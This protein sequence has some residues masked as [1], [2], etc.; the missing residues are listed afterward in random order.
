MTYDLLGLPPTPEE[1]EAFVAQHAQDPAAAVEALV[2]RLLASPRYGERWGRHWLD[3]VRFGESNGFERN[4][5]IDDLWPFRDYVIRSL[6]EDKPFNQFIIEQL[7]GDVIGHDQPDVEVAAAFLVAGPYDDVGNQDVV[8]QAN[9]RA[10]TLDDIIT[11]TSGAFL[12]LTV[13]CARCH[14]HKFDPVPTED[15]YRMRAAF[16]GVKHG[17][18]VVASPEERQ[19]FAAATKPLNERQAQ[20][21]SEQTELNKAIDARSRSELKKRTF[22]R[23]KFDPQWTEEPFEPVEAR[24]VKFQ[25]HANTGNPN[26]AVGSRLV[27]FEVWTAGENSR[28]VALASNGGRAEG[29]RSATAE[30]F[31]E[32]YGPQFTIDGKFSEQWFIGSPAELTITLAQPETIERI[33]FGNSRGV[34]FLNKKVQGETPCDYQ[35]LVSLDGKEWQE[36][37]TSDDREPWSDRHALERMRREV[38]T[39]EESRRLGELSRELAQVQTRAR[40]QSRRCACYGSER[41][42]SRRSRRWCIS[43]AT[44]RS[45]GNRCCQA[46]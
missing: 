10:A 3:V 21:A 34:T 36:V 41:L 40:S 20:L 45:R 27:E 16:E 9:I 31:P 8:A 15:Y 33:E 30:D 14:N 6:N 35:V 28:N 42:R 5:I 11:A 26:S 44:R 25:M 2:D 38:I 13:N 19:Q 24:F 4:V 17:R 23:P 18:R 7:A 43:A 22:A 29:A 12:G 37:A 32:A 46:A 1:V 39:A